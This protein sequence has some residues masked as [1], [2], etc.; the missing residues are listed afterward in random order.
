MS[1]NSR[2]NRKHNLCIFL[3]FSRKQDTH[4][5][6]HNKLHLTQIVC[7]YSLHHNIF[8]STRIEHC[9]DKLYSLLFLNQKYC[10][11]DQLEYIR[12]LKHWKMF[13]LCKSREFFHKN[14]WQADKLLSILCILWIHCK[15]H[16][17]LD[18]NN[19]FRTFCIDQWDKEHQ[20][21]F[22]LIKWI[23]RHR[24]NILNLN[25]PILCK[26]N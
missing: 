14:F 19:K 12:M 9:W 13:F 7:Q 16:N 24:L 23:L 26:E 21:I 1:L 10:I 8:H 6:L 11:L 5:Q 25:Y 4:Y 15:L 3:L 2:W 22:H 17:Q 20:N 18:L